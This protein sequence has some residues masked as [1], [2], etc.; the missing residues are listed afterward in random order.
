M[1]FQ[2]FISKEFNIKK[3]LLTKLDSMSKLVCFNQEIEENGQFKY[4]TIDCL[5]KF[6]EKEYNL[7]HASLTRFSIVKEIKSI[8]KEDEKEAHFIFVNSSEPVVLIAIENDVQES[9]YKVNKIFRS[10]ILINVELGYGMFMFMPDPQD[11]DPD[12]TTVI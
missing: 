2:A 7:Q 6:E 5:R 11:P 8:S 4:K 1:S 3:V 12:Y 9:K 10:T